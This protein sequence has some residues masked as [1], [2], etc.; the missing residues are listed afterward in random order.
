[1]LKSFFV[2]IFLFTVTHFVNAEQ[3]AIDKEKM[4]LQIDLIK[5]I[6]EIQY[7]PFIWK[8][9]YFGW[10]LDQEINKA[11]NKINQT[12]NLKDFQ[13]VLK[14]FF[15]SCRDY[16]VDIFF[17]STEEAYLPFRV[18]PIN[19]KLFLSYIDRKKLPE[20]IFPVN[21][22]DEL[23]SFDR[24]SAFQVLEELKESEFYYSNE[25]TDLSMAA[26]LLT[27]RKGILGQI[28]PQGF[29]ELTFWSSK[30]ERSETYNLSWIYT[31]E[32]IQPSRKELHKKNEA[33]IATPSEI[34]SY[35]KREMTLPEYNLSMHQTIED[36][37]DSLGSRKSF[38][39]LLGKSRWIAKDNTLFYAYLFELP[40]GKLAGYVRI[41]HY[42]GNLRHI[43]EFGYLIDY[44][45]EFAEILIIDQVNN[46]GGSPFYLYA[47]T[48]MLIDTP[49]ETPK[50]RLS[51]SYLEAATAA[52]MLPILKE[53]K[54][55]KE[56]QKVLG[57]N[58][59]G[60][61]VELETVRNI[62]RYLQFMSEEWDT[63]KTLSDP[64]T[65]YGID[66]VT[67]HAKHRYTKP[68]IV[69]TNSQDFSGGDFFPAI[70]QDN[71][72]AVIF[73]ERTAGAGGMFT[74]YSHPNSLGIRCYHLT[75]SIAERK[76]KRP[77]ENLGVDPNFHYSLTQFDLQNNYIEYKNQLI[78][79]TEEILNGRNSIH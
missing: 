40:S 20:T 65:L 27:N 4:H 38:V 45:Q 55:D 79:I 48:S 10:S 69:L 16:H 5:S 39:P 62:V 76:N 2:F 7:A 13:R 42:K 1:M 63:G 14:E 17:Y 49:V 11:K 26:I 52:T 8:N 61:S 66:T 78:S 64:I 77:I 75:L 73:G 34:I 56:A 54:S 18:K 51:L 72:R 58:I 6:F 67:P 21:I 70:M 28:I 44:F 32:K 46:P 68:I 74:T 19:G 53:I 23:I 9:E 15:R 36:T 50:H 24:K 30:K 3:T 41:P 22:G 12:Q 29:A 47:L 59:D 43:E 33:S 35:L 57:N 31:P 37:E 71:E 60:Y 25:Q